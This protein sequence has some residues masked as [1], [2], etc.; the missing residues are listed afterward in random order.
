[1]KVESFLLLN[2]VQEH[3]LLTNNKHKQNEIF[4]NKMVFVV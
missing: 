3:V 1:M 2:A 4:I